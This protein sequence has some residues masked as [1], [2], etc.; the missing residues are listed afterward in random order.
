MIVRFKNYLVILS[1]FISGMVIPMI[2]FAD[3]VDPI[4]EDIKVGDTGDILSTEDITTVEKLLICKIS[5]RVEYHHCL[6]EANSLTEEM[7]CRDDALLCVE[8]CVGDEEGYFDY[9]EEMEMVV[10]RDGEM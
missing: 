5:C 2:T 4:I 9:D 10:D 8:E 3:M 1:L 6:E 7:F